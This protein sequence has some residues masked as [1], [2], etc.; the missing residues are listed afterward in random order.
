MIKYKPNIT[1]SF[2]CLHC[3]A[4]NTV[5]DNT[6]FLG[7]HTLAVCNCLECRKSFHHT[8]PLGHAANFPI[9]FN[10]DGKKNLI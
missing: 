10:K 9:A 6:E 7:M 8:Y 5:V 1:P 3:G 4:A 2:T